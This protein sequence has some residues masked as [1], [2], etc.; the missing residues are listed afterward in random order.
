MNNFERGFGKMYRNKAIKK[1]YMR[2]RMK[3]RCYTTSSSSFSSPFAHTCGA[4][5]AAAAASA[6][7]LADVRLSLTHVT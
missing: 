5:A 3:F 7:A 1:G 6:A 2:N 4:I